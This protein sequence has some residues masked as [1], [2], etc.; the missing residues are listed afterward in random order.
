MRKNLKYLPILLFGL[1]ISCNNS[2]KRQPE[3]NLTEPETIDTTHNSQNSLD[4]FGKYEGILPCADCPGIKTTLIIDTNGNF[5]Y[6]ES[7]QERDY[8]SS[9]QGKIMWHNNGSIIHLHTNEIDVKFKVGEN[10]LFK[11]DSQDKI[12]TGSLAEKYQLHKIN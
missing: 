1:S 2:S 11:L 7:Y 5:T 9:T 12:I 6:E 4:W 3:I 10:I 8:T